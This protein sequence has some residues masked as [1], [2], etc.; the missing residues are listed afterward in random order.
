VIRQYVGLGPTNILCRPG[1]LASADLARVGVARISVGPSLFRLLL[2][3]LEAAIG[4]FRRFDDESLW[5]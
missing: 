4:A 2:R 1:G 3:R 5:S